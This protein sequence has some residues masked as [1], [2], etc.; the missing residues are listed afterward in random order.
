MNPFQKLLSDQLSVFN[1]NRAN[2]FYILVGTGEK[3]HRSMV[4]D[5]MDLAAWDVGLAYDKIVDEC[6]KR[7][8]TLNEFFE[9]LMKALD[10]VSAVA[11]S[12]DYQI[13]KYNL[14]N[15]DD[16]MDMI[17]AAV[18]GGAFSHAVAWGYGQMAHSFV[19]QQKHLVSMKD[20]AQ[21]HILS[22]PLSD[23]KI[24]K[25]WEAI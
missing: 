5:D 8:F 14:D 17:A 16:M 7:Y 10:D 15:L 9:G 23:N 18:R 11:D 21:Q 6:A 25:F 19:Q 20:Y 22:Y 24:Y 2:D 3:F 12:D 1:S 4:K 13:L